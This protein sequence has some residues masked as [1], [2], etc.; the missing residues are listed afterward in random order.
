[1]STTVDVICIRISATN[2]LMRRKLVSQVLCES[3][4][5]LKGKWGDNFSKKHRSLYFK[6]IVRTCDAPNDSENHSEN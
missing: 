1:M 4:L 6:S 5:M 2:Q 3:C